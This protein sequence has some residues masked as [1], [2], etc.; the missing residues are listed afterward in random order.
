MKCRVR[1]QCGTLFVHKFQL[2]TL[3][4]FQAVKFGGFKG[5]PGASTVIWSG[6][7]CLGA[8]VVSWGGSGVLG[9]GGQ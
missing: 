2:M 8:S 4:M 9:V 5:G 3:A 7:G 6:S 1:N